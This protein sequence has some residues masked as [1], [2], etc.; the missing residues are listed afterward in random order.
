MNKLK[1]KKFKNKLEIINDSFYKK[2]F[3][4]NW[5]ETMLN[6]KI[7]NIEFKK[8]LKKYNNIFIK[9]NK[10]PIK[11]HNYLKK[12]NNI[13]SIYKLK[14]KKFL[15]KLLKISKLKTFN[16]LLYYYKKNINQKFKNN[17]KH[18][19]K[20]EKYMNNFNFNDSQ[21]K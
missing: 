2:K 5:K 7:E 12:L 20:N 8:T 10:K 13:N 9:V 4:Y 1:L 3:F 11:A 16:I 15:E 17:K 6:N 19:N 14:I 18:I 21:K